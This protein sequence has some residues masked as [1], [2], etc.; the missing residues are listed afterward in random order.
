MIDKMVGDLTINNSEIKIDWS[1]YQNKMI[2][3]KEGINLLK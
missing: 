2:L 3:T 1:E